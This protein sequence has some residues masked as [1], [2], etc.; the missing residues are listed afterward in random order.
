MI[1][2]CNVPPGYDAG[3]FH[4]L[5]AGVYIRLEMVKKVYFTGQ[6]PHGGTP[7]LA[8]PGVT[9]VDPSAIRCVVILYPSKFM[10][11]GLTKTLLAAANVKGETVS[12]PLDF[13][14]GQ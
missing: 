2:C 4:L 1:T 12:I 14:Y 5:A 13:F 6:L 11:Y 3:R 9:V 10:I 8:P 7:P